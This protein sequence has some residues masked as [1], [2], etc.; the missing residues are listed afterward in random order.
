M[1]AIFILDWLGTE[2]SKISFMQHG[3]GLQRVPTVLTAHLPRGNSMQIAVNQLDELVPCVHFAQPPSVEQAGYVVR[4]AIVCGVAR[5]AHSD[6]ARRS[7]P[8]S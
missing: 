3:S 8:D 7:R 6:D 4:F 5:R 1:A 2:D